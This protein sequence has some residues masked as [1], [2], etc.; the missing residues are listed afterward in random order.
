[1]DPFVYVAFNSKDGKQRFLG[2]AFVG[3]SQAEFEKAIAPGGSK[4]VQHSVSSR[5]SHVVAVDLDTEKLRAL[6]A[7]YPDK[8]HL[9]K[10]DVSQ[11][12]TNVEAVETAIR[13]GK[14]LTSLIL[15]AATFKPLGPFPRL[16][17][18]HWKRAYDINFFSIVHMVSPFF[19]TIF[20]K[21]C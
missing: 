12:S 21:P 11:E 15:N 19:T 1:M 9:V 13:Q 18:V 17:L 5:V 14:R 16:S 2:P 7:S 20:S 3:A 4:R 6:K 8:L 10:G